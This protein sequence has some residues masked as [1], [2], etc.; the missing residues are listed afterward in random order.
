MASADDKVCSATTVAH[1]F[2][3]YLF[4]FA[5]FLLKTVCM[6]S[7]RPMERRNVCIDVNFNVNFGTI[8]FNGGEINT[9]GERSFRFQNR[10]HAFIN[11]VKTVLNLCEFC[12]REVR[13]C[14]NALS[15]YIL[16]LVVRNGIMGS[17][18]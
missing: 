7:I 15:G 14:M 2:H 3:T 12:K 8:D 11:N 13:K 5:Y 1:F 4:L 16:R 18:Y 17:N 6:Y 9:W 10:S